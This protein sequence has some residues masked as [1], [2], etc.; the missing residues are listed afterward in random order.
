MTAPSCLRESFSPRNPFTITDPIRPRDRS[1]REKRVIMN[2]E[3]MR[4]ALRSAVNAVAPPK[5]PAPK[6]LGSPRL[7]EAARAKA[8]AAPRLPMLEALQAPGVLP[9]REAKA[10]ATWATTFFPFQLAWLF[11]PLMFALCLKSRQIGM[12][13]TTAGVATMWAAAL[14]ETTTV[15]SIGQRESNE[16]LDKAKAH[17]DVLVTL[18][19]RRAKAHQKGEEL[20]F[21]SGGRVI[22]LPSSTGGRS[23]SGNVFL[24]EFAYLENPEKVWDGASAV[25]MHGGKMRVGSTP[26]GV[27]NMFHKLW[28]DEKEHKGWALHEI[29]IYRAIADGMKVNIDDCWKMAHGDPRV[30][31]QLFECSFLDGEL[32]Y[33]PTEL[34]DQAI[35]YDM[36]WFEGETFA[37]LDIG[38]ENDLSSLTVL[39]ADRRGIL[40]EQETITCKRT[41][42]EAQ[43]AMVLASFENWG[44]RTIAVDATGLGAVPAQ[45]LQKALGRNRVIALPFT[46][47]TKELLATG[48]YERFA[49][50]TLRI[51]ASEPMRK[52]VLSL[53]RIVTSAGN[54]RYDA[55]RTRDGHADRAWSLA[56]ACHADKLYRIHGPA[57]EYGPGDYGVAA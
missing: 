34:V 4:A 50:S 46:M 28:T 40:H 32:Q 29:S 27:G 54:I 45:L 36:S 35:D 18:G 15:I 16:V 43:Q 57:F 8:V 11:E 42:W 6:N 23:F 47:Q 22:A 21:E 51:R 31:A 12:S 19:S 7:A 17:A 2:I 26:N 39:K 44:W 20:R 10:I 1:I 53:R 55:P 49:R 14:G 38:L 25:A 5:A 56:L 13:H 37:G 3:G 33:I 48:L 52:D 30:F 9:P 24:D 41:N